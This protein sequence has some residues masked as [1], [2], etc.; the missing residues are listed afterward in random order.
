[1]RSTKPPPTNFYRSESYAR[2]LRELYEA[3]R[4]EDQLMDVATCFYSELY[5]LPERLRIAQ[6]RC[7]PAEMGRL[8][9][10]FVREALALLHPSGLWTP[11]PERQYTAFGRIIARLAMAFPRPDQIPVNAGPLLVDAALAVHLDS[12]GRSEGAAASEGKGADR[13]QFYDDGTEVSEESQGDSDTAD[14]ADDADDADNEEGDDLTGDDVEEFEGG[15]LGRWRMK[16]T[17]SS[18]EM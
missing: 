16:R 3:I 17:Q 7:N 14:D 11:L 13:D 1:M 12:E 10:A 8:H 6:I 5:R 15:L 4:E 2:L 18:E 9:V